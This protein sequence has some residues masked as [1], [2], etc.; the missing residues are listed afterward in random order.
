MSSTRASWYI[1]IGSIL[2]H[3]PLR[4]P[5]TH[6][7][8][9]RIIEE[10][11]DLYWYE[12]IDKSYATS[13]ENEINKKKTVAFFNFGEK[14]LGY[15]LQ[16]GYDPFLA[17]IHISIRHPRHKD[18]VKKVY[19]IAKKLGAEVFWDSKKKLKNPYPEEE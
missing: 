19:A 1:G 5:I 16:I 9:I 6:D 8:F 17:Y 14:T 11:T 2:Y 10:D 13:L 3:S 7:D 18:S 15:D 12:D 4:I